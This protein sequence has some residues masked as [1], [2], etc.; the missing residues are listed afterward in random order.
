MGAQRRVDGCS[1]LLD[2]VPLISA[3]LHRAARSG[4]IPGRILP[5]LYFGSEALEPGMFVF[6][7]QCEIAVL[8][9]A[10]LLHRLIGRMSAAV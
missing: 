10:A 3:G 6:V 4:L 7:M 2:D 5:Q 9:I 1:E 8:R